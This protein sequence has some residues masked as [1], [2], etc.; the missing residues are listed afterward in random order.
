MA[1]T[2][3][4]DLIEEAT[5]FLRGRV[6]HTPLEPSPK[7]SQLLG[8]PAWLKL[9]CLQTTGSF[10]LRGALFRLSRLS[11]EEKRAG[12]FT[13]SAGNHGKGVAY[14]A[15]ALGLTP[16]IV[17]PSSIDDSKYRAMVAMDA[18]VIRSRFPGYDETEAWAM[19]EAAKSGKVWISAFDEDAIMAGNGGSLAAEI[20]EDLPQAQSFVLP[21]GG[22]GLAAGV[23]FLVKAKRPD[24]IVV[25]CNHELSPAL[26]LSLEQ[27]YAA[28]RL[29]AAT[30]TAGGIEGGIGQR[31]FEVLRSRVDR[32][33]LLSEAEL[34]EAVRWTFDAHQY[35]IETASAAPIAACLHD[36]T[37][38][39]RGPTV[40]V[41][42][43]RNLSIDTLRLIL[44]SDGSIVA[45]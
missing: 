22:G 1:V 42:T 10:K 2:L 26:A 17:V 24:A 38:E 37:G 44:G 36:K 18:K 21:V 19:E 8:V 15:K 45:R 41:L 6:L 20:L 34:F 4:L 30:T 7:L 43:G 25:G 28:T 23:S 27:G 13:C 9:E 35:V 33:A 12:V 31:T 5:R 40:I 29:P 16:T 39:L 3:T 14:A 32:V 11:E